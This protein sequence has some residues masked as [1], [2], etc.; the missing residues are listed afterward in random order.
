MRHLSD[1][2]WTLTR[3]VL[4]GAVVTAVVMLSFPVVAAVGSNLILGKA[5]SVDAVTSLSGAAATNLRITN[6]LAGGAALDLRVVS[7]AAPFKVNS[8]VRVANLNADRVDGKHAS[9]FLLTTGTAANAALLDNLDSTAFALSGHAHDAS[10]VSVVGAPTVGNF[11]TLTAGGELANSSWGPASFAASA[12]THSALDLVS[13]TLAE[14]RYSAYSDLGA[15]GFLND[16]SASDLLTRGQADGRFLG[17]GATAANSG[18]LDGLDSTAFAL[19]AHDHAAYLA[20]GATAADSDLLDGQDSADFAGVGWRCPIG[21]S[22]L[23]LDGAGIA[24]CGGQATVDSASGVGTGTS[25]VLGGDGFPTIAYHDN[26]NEDL[27]VADCNDPACAGGDETITTVDSSGNVGEYTAM[28]LGGDGFPTIAYYGNSNLKVA[29]CND[30]ACAGG[31]ETITTV[32][33]GSLAGQ[34]PSMVLGGDGFP[35]IAYYDNTNL[36][37]RVV[38]CNDPACAGGDETITTVDPNGGQT[39]SIVLGGDG[40]PIIAYYDNLNHLLKVAD[41]NDPACAGGDETISVVG[42]N[43]VWT[44]TVLGGDGFPIIAYVDNTNYDLK[45]ADCNDPACAGGD[46]PITTVDSS[47]DVGGYT[48]MVLGGDGF[49]IIAY[50]DNTNYDLKVADCNDPACAGGNETLTRADSGGSVGAYNSMVIDVGFPVIAYY[51]ATNGRLKV[52]GV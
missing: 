19:V 18:L 34:F 7:G 23:G 3:G 44:A 20:I 21:S 29:D 26:L 49:P 38:D 37:L 16:D 17:L 8:T 33:S 50:Y 45:V 5:N 11:P 13:G 1:P 52:A 28:V 27:K 2:G 43:G 6:S 46:D 36:E 32:D 9:A 12:H 40:F 35:T 15:E 22:F 4:I 51:D 47:C 41:C 31:D 24:R 25:M 30:P 14:T 42:S 48:S 10:Y 39:P